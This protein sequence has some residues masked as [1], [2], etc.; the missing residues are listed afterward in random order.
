MP[1]RKGVIE[2]FCG[3]GGF[4][5]GWDRAGF[6]LLAALDND[7]TALRSHEL[8][9]SEGHGALLNRDL[10]DFEPEQLAEFL[11]GRPRHLLAI[12]GGPPCQGWSKV[13]RGKIRSL[14]HAARNLLADPRNRLYRRFLRYV[15][16]FHPALCVMEN[17]PGMLSIERRNIADLVVAMG[18][19]QIKTGSASRTDRVAKYNQLLRIEEEVGPSARFPGRSALAVKK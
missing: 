9:F 2:L 7:A 15:E 19:G 1:V 17:V 12:V 8:N 5:W 16:Y 18:T 4:T 6:D 11:G 10:A 13:G 3:A 14:R